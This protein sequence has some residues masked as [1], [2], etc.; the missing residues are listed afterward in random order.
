[1][2]RVVK[3]VLKKFLLDPDIKGLD[4]A[5]Q[6]SYFLFN[7]RNTCSESAQFPSEK[8]LSFTPKT[9]LDLVNPKLSFK[10]HLTT[11]TCEEDFS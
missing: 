3:E 6:I 9:T 11:H 7:Y 4:I 10:N 5:D 8:L 1:M 2:V